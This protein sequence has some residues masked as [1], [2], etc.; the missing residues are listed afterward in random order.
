MPNSISDCDPRT[1]IRARAKAEGF[2]VVRFARA[3]AARDTGAHLK[4]Y[5]EQGRHG[6]MDWMARDPER[7]ADPKELWP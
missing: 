6:S 1:A 5:L 2:D 7:R 3:E 4:T